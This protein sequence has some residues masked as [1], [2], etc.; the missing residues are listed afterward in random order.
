MQISRHDCKTMETRQYTELRI[1]IEAL[2]IS[3]ILYHDKVIK[4]KAT[5][6]VILFKSLPMLVNKMFRTYLT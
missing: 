6:E 3:T 4:F 5:F 1:L 2:A